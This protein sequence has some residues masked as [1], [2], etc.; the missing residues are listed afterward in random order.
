MTIDQDNIEESPP[1]AFA[2]ADKERVQHEVLEREAV[3]ERRR[4]RQMG[5]SSGTKNKLLGGAAILI[6]VLG[7]FVVAVGPSEALKMIGLSAGDTS[8]AKSSEVDLTVKQQ[9]KE[10]SELEFGVPAPKEAPVADNGVD[11]DILEL[12]K[13]LA[14]LQKAPVEPQL[15]AEQIQALMNENL[16]KIEAK[17]EEERKALREENENIR[18]KAAREE[19]EARKLYEQN[20]IQQDINSKKEE[21]AKSQRESKLLVIDDS[22]DAALAGGADAGATGKGGQNEQFLAS[23]AD[24]SFETS[25]SKPLADP[26]KTVIQGTIISGVL[27][28]AINTELPGNIRAQV[29]EPVFSFDGT[30]VLMPAG[31]VLIGTF[32]S[33]VELEQKR[34]LIAWNRAV[35]PDGQ[36]VA[37]GS[38]GTDLLGRSGTAGN[39]D[40]RY[41]K[42]FGAAVLISAIN[43]VPGMITTALKSKIAP[44]R[45]DSGDGPTIVIN[46]GS[47]SGGGDSQD[48]PASSVS[49]A[50][51]SQSA[52]VLGKYLDLPPIIRIP[53]GEEIRIFVNRDLV[54]R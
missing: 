42:K 28:T 49:K 19:A 22:P 21:V 30:H 6:A 26:S 35:T 45:Q 36:S 41:G 29:I 39:V 3:L 25:R 37:I 9:T 18:A 20:S 23:A 47:D 44:A 17:F 24:A 10:I 50:F 1:S 5:E 48:D 52:E 34:V 46:T 38:T 14:E 54:F 27:E 12:Q 11:K 15:T 53:Q 4:A 31:T 32:N 7:V 2:A 43:V 51:A 33:K 16:N 40:N 8:N 13:R